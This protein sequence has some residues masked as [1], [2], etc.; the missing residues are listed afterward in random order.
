MDTALQSVPLN[1]GARRVGTPQR[2]GPL[3]VL[4]LVGEAVDG[5]R[6]V[7]PLTGMKLSRVAGYGKVEMECLKRGDVD[8]IGIVPLHIGYIQD[9]AQNHALCRSGLFAGGQKR[10]FEDACCVQQTQGGYLEGREQWFFILPLALRDAALQLR[11]TV[12]YGKLWPAIGKLNEAFGK[13]T[14]GHLDELIVRERT[15]LTQYNGRFERVPDQV[16]A[17]FVLDG[18]L[19]G[20]EL[21]PSPTYFAEVWPALICF[22]YGVEAMARERGESRAVGERPFTARDL[23]S[24]RDEVETRRAEADAELARSLAEVPRQPFT[25]T[26]EERLLDLKLTTV[27][28]DHFSGQLVKRD[29]T[30]IYASIAARPE[31]LN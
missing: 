25:S 22:C 17:L 18:K 4:P 7:P 21:A 19:V 28:N 5:D 10:M 29:D 30:T 23:A 31:W 6:F 3:T 9:G 1:L 15:H 24:L 16:G 8:S 13:N 14:R 27:S 12:N 26:E 20:I 11:G 2:S